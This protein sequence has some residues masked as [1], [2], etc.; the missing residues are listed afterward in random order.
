MD[1]LVP[2]RAIDRQLARTHV[3]TPDQDIVDMIESAPGWS[4]PARA[5]TPALRRQTLRY[6]LWRHHKNL[7]EYAWVMGSHAS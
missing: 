7:A 6:A 4:D 3:G 1:K 2:T 5:W